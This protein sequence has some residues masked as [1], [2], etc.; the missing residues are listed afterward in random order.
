MTKRREDMAAQPAPTVEAL[1]NGADFVAVVRLTN[2]A[3]TTVLAM[4]GATCEEVPA[5]SLG[6]LLEQGLVAPKGAA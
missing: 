4:P 5:S 2:K 6:W 1:L 3:G